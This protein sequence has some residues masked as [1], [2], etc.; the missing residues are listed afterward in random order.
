MSKAIED[1]TKEELLLE[2]RAIRNTL[3]NLEQR[4]NDVVRLACSKFGNDRQKNASI[5]NTDATIFEILL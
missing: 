2:F 1:M 3:Q 4:K 5:L